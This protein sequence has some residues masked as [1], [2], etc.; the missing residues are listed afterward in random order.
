MVKLSISALLLCATNLVAGHGYLK[1]IVVNGQTYMAWQVGQDDYVTPT[2]ERYARK[3]ADN[4]PVPNFTTK[5][6]TELVWDQWNSAHS[7]PVFTYIAQCTNNDCKTFKGDTGN[8]WVKID[9]LAYNPSANPPWAS[10]FL[11]ER[12]AKWSVVVPPGLTPGEYLLRHEILGLHVAGTRMGAQFYPSCTHIRVTQGGST[13]LPSGIA[14]PGSY[15]PDD[16]AGILVELWRI[17]QGQVDYTAPGGPVWS[18]A[19]PNAT[20]LAHRKRS[21]RLV[22][23]LQKVTILFGFYGSCTQGTCKDTVP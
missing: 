13:K 4:G 11:R 22:S 23:L 19:A 8:V 17:N 18:G 1:S 7:G 14:L 10:D 15:S 5:D 16:K 20:G 2:P 6:I 21:S 12:G 3:L 9:Q